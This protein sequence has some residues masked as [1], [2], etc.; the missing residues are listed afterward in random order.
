MQNKILWNII[1]QKKV[2]ENIPEKPKPIERDYR[3]IKYDIGNF[4][5]YNK[6]GNVLLGKIININKTNLF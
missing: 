3:G 6:S 2:K 1:K 5:A 4:V